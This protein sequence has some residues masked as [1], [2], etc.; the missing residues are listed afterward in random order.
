MCVH[1]Y[2]HIY[3]CMCVY[4]HVH[5]CIHMKASIY[6]CV[7]SCVCAFLYVCVCVW[8]TRLRWKWLRIEM[9][10][11][12]P[13]TKTWAGRRKQLCSSQGTA[14]GAGNVTPHCPSRGGHWFPESKPSTLAPDIPE[15]T[16]PVM[17]PDG[18]VMAW[19]S[20]S[21]P[22]TWQTPEGAWEKTRAPEPTPKKGSACTKQQE[23]IP[24]S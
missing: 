17:Q 5:M 11:I 23:I 7:C 14:Q 2:T 6:T 18:R 24:S 9:C 3:V 10:W 4:M 13:G 16:Q 15:T 1:T 12:L 19:R 21:H 20:R 22:D 8:M